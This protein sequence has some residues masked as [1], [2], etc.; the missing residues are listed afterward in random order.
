MNNNNQLPSPN[1]NGGRRWN[2][3]LFDLKAQVG[4]K[5]MADLRSSGEMARRKAG[6][7]LRA[8]MVASNSFI[9]TVVELSGAAPYSPQVLT[10]PGGTQ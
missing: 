5:R 1:N 10:P 6:V 2:A 8:E 4:T 7:A 9:R 3:A